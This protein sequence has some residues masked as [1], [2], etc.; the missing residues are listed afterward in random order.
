M[1]EKIARTYK[2]RLFR[3]IFSDKSSLLELYNALNNTDYTEETELEIVD[4]EDAVYLSMKNDKAFVLESLSMNFYEHQSTWC[5]NMPLRGFF[6]A[7]DTYRAYI[8]SK[9][10]DLYSIKQ[11]VLPEPRY[12]VFYNGD[13][14]V[15][16]RTE[17]KLSDMFLNQDASDKG[18]FEWTATV[19]N[20]NIG[21]NNVI[22]DKSKK[23]RDYAT[24]IGK[25]KTYK[26]ELPL[27]SAIDKAVKECI[28]EDVLRD[29]L[30]KNRSEVMNTLLTE[31]DE[32][33]SRARLARDAQE[34]GMQLKA[35]E[36]A[37]KLKNEGISI[38]II[39]RCTGLS[40]AE[41]EKL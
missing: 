13:Q 4:L 6:Y 19:L 36:T 26:N 30:I 23:L 24:L 28:E 41:I 14:E 25:I 21:H 5:P 35:Q 34:I 32:E 20:I 37:S 3:R 22:L 31:Y 38:D 16:D 39:A 29:F 10:Y 15:P 2:D 11:I 1:S 8:T 33:K 18:K 27:K 17:L 12:I 40:E 9:D 7:A